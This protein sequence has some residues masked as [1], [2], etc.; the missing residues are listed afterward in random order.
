MSAHSELQLKSYCAADW[1][2]CVDTRRSTYGFCVFLGESLLSWKCKK[3]QVVSRSFAKFEYRAMATVTSEIIWSIALLQTF[4]YTQKH[5]ISLYCDSK[6]ALYIAANPMFHERTK[7]IKSDCHFIREKIEDRI[8]KTFHV[9]TRHQL[10]D[11]FTKPLSQKQFL[12]Q[13]NLINIY[14][15]S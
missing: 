9:P 7:H 12:Y 1:A 4:G 10:A 13:I 11:L 6:V 5:P 3:Q 15:S 14:S 2:A 8:I